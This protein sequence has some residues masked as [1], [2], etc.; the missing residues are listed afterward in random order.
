MA[1]G[2]W[3][4]AGR[5]TRFALA[6]GCAAAVLA[7]CG[8][9][10]PGARSATE[11][12]APAP[13]TAAGAQTGSRPLLNSERIERRFGSYGVEVLDSDG[14][15]RVSNLFSGSGA[16]RVCRTFAVVWFPAEVDSRVREEHAAVLD[17]GSIGAVFAGRGWAVERRDRHVGEIPRPAAADRLA[18]LMGLSGVPGKLATEVYTLSVR[19]DGTDVDYARIAEVHHPEHLTLAELH[20]LAGPTAVEGFGGDPELAAL[21]AL[22]ERAAR[23]PL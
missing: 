10:S 16:A 14:R 3:S 9:G 5:A 2:S 17:G 8:P 4:L 22:V 19:K 7:A 13:T 11:Q 12:A 18:G 23:G 6:L 15:V 1:P 21:L 20:V